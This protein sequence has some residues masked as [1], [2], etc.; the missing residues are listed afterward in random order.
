M[1]IATG[2]LGFHAASEF[3]SRVKYISLANC[4][5]EPELHV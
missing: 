2:G 1:L 5:E 4:R 3:A